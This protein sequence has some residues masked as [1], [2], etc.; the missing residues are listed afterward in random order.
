MIDSLGLMTF[1][2]RVGRSGTRR[3]GSELRCGWMC[4]RLS[5]LFILLNTFWWKSAVV[6]RNPKVSPA[7]EM[8]SWAIV[9]R[10]EWS[11]DEGFWKSWP[12]EFL[13]YAAHNSTAYFK[14]R[15]AKPFLH[16]C[17]YFFLV[18]PDWKWNDALANDAF[19]VFLSGRFYVL[20]SQTGSIRWLIFLEGQNSQS[21]FI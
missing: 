12:K 21:I 4:R 15:E 13:K 16:F 3:E 11:A 10:T 7:A 17:V 9:G 5:S 6:Q 18:L 20:K 14:K 19:S 1:D 8:M 2:A